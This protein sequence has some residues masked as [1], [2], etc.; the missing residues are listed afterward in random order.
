MRHKIGAALILFG[1]LC[2]LAAF[3][4][5]A[6]RAPDW[7]IANQS[8]YSTLVDLAIGTSSPDCLNAPGY[9]ERSSICCTQNTPGHTF[10]FLNQWSWGSRAQAMLK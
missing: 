9:S 4:I 1:V 10:C 5:D 7:M 2:V 8:G 3:C 6:T